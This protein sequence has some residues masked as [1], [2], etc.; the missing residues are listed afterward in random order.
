MVD[1]SVTA[2]RRVHVKKLIVA[3]QSRNAMPVME[4]GGLFTCSQEPLLQGVVGVET[5]KLKLPFA[6]THSVL[7]FLL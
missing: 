1:K 2:L 6:P 7:T 3:N 5:G 4:L